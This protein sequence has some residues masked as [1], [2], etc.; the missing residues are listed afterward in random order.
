MERF[1]KLWA[2]VATLAV[3]LM[4]TGVALA[5]GGEVD[6]R[7]GVELESGLWKLTEGAHDYSN[8]DQFVGLGLRRGFSDRWVANLSYRYGTIRPGVASPDDDAGLTFDS[9]HDVATEIHHPTLTLEYLARPGHAFRPYLGFGAGVTAWRVMATTDQGLMAS[10]TTVQGFASDSDQFEKLQRTDLTLAAELG[11]QFWLS[12]KLS[13]RLGARY[14]ILPGNDLDNVGI[15]SWDVERDPQYV[16]A[17][18]GL[19]QGVIGATLWFGG[20]RDRDRDG[21]PDHLDDCPGVPEDLDGFEDTD[22][23]PDYDNDGDGI[24]DDMDLC[25]DEAEDFDGFQDGDGCPDPDNDGDGIPDHLD[26]CPDQPED[27]DGFQDDD[28]CPDPDNDG[29]GVL[30]HLDRCP[31]TPA[32][33][34]VDEFGCPEP[35]AEAAPEIRALDSGLVLEGVTFKSGSAQVLPSSLAVLQKVADSLKQHPEVRVEVQGHT[36]AAGSAE[37]NRDLSARRAIA[38]RDFLIQLG[39]SPSRVTAV[40]LGEDYPVTTNATAEGRAKNR[41]VELHRTR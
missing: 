9:F 32:G 3:I 19:L 18:R 24:P 13:L 21:I 30:D 29:D 8:V 5:G 6:R 4:T 14:H 33:V 31:D 2:T 27:F 34:A 28:G 35:E 37:F 38:V 11:A 39:V 40:G 17:N 41:R 15:G 12:S 25:P 23:C 10:G 16:D 26:Q 7:W 22:G 1:L 36:D 20:S